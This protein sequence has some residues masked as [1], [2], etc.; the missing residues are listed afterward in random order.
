MTGTEPCSEENVAAAAS[1]GE[2]GCAPAGAHTVDSC[3]LRAG[4]YQDNPHGLLASTVCVPLGRWGSVMWVSH[5][6]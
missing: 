4:P 6:T 1:A 2:E 3:L 5:M